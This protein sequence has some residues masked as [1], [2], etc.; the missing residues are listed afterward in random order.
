MELTRRGRVEGLLKSLG[1]FGLG[2][3]ELRRT[4]PGLVVAAHGP[5]TAA[6]AQRPGVEVDVVPSSVTLMGL[7]MGL[8]GWRVGEILKKNYVI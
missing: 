6:G 2:F 4:T 1:E 8:F 5:F 7:P 3:G